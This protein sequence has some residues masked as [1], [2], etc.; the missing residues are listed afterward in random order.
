MYDYIIVTHLPAFYKVNL[1]NEL[2]NK[3]NILVVFIAVE[4]NEKRS[5]D[6]SSLSNCNFEYTILS[7][8]SFQNRNK[9]KTLYKLFL[10]L[11]KKKYKKILLSG[12]DLIEFWFLALLSPNGKNSLALESTVIESNTNGVRGGV[13]KVFLSMISTVFASG[14]LHVDLLNKLN[15]KKEIRITKGVGIINKPKYKNINK[16]YQKRFLYIGRLSQEKNINLLIS[17]FNELQDYQLTIIGDG[18]EKVN[19]M[20]IANNNIKFIDPVENVK[21]KYFFYENDIFILPSI[22]EPWGLVVEEAL[23]FGLPVIVSDRCGSSE[24]VVNDINGYIIPHD[25]KTYI[26]KT[27]IDIDIEGKYDDLLIGA[28]KFIKNNKDYYQVEEY[29]SIFK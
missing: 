14:K 9:M 19:L 1:Y 21:L 17:I 22:S 20:A 23:Y 27:I 5:S 6:F 18:I 7:D 29:V 8:R 3:L 12:W 13:K 28:S 15:Y 16:V 11:N 10:V 25:N 26:K 2:S 24:L 4:T